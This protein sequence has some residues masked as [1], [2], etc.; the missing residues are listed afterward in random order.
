MTDSVSEYVGSELELFQH[1]INWKKYWKSKILPFVGEDV[2]E[3]GAGI[4]SSTIGLVD[5]ADC[6]TWTCLEPDSNLLSQISSKIDKGILPDKLSLVNG[7]IDDLARSTEYDLIL[8]IDVLEHIKEDSLELEKAS[9][10][11]KKGGRLVVLVPA[12]NFLFSPFDEAIGHYRRYNKK[13]IKDYSTPSLSLSKVFYLDS[14]GLIASLMNKALLKQT[15]PTLKQISFWD[16][17]IVPIS[18]LVDLVSFNLMGKTVV[19]VWVKK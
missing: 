9:K 2:L 4:G 14:V 1:A 13:M 7:T 3:V 19:G 17:V 18:R 12:H 16:N 8:Y 11:L 6:K 10:R 5:S 15:S